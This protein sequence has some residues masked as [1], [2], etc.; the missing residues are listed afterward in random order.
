[1]ADS[2]PNLLILE[3]VAGALGS[4]CQEVVFVGG[5]AA[6]LLLTQTRAELIRATEDVDLVIRA[7]TKQDYY[8]FEQ[9]L[10]AKGFANDLQKN[11]PICRWKHGHIRVDIM[12]SI[13]LVLG[14]SN[15]WYPHACESAQAYQLPS[16]HTINLIS[17]PCFIATK[18]EAFKNRGKDSTGKPDYIG[19]HDLE[20]VI[21]VIDRRPE[22]F[23]ECTKEPPELR[24][25]LAGEFRTLL[26]QQNFTTSLPGHLLGD[27]ASQARLP[28]LFTKLQLLTTLS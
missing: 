22:L 19:S 1:M 27:V 5:C 18:L 20:D 16:G 12:P 11:A 13:D 14:F 15:I 28:I 21:S 23:D 25:Y 10:R 24:E 4:L 7:I 17:A 9:R 3:S 2:N 8:Q 6:G 26:K